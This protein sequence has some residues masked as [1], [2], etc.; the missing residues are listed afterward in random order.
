MVGTAGSFK[1]YGGTTVVKDISLFRCG[2]P[3]WGGQEFGAVMVHVVGGNV[4]ADIR[5]SDI[6]AYDPTY[7]GL[8]IQC[9]A[10]MTVKGLRFEN[11]KLINCGTDG[12]YMTSGASGSGTFKNISVSCARAPLQ[13]KAFE[14]F[15]IIY[16]TGNIGWEIDY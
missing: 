14:K 10:G 3:F 6:D 1:P 16:D 9:D 15:E 5:I 7:S 8:H 2:G 12:I 4:D 11:I 13:N